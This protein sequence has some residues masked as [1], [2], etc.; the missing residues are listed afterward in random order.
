[1]K[2]HY[3]LNRPWISSGNDGVLED[4]AGFVADDEMRNKYN[5]LERISSAIGLNHKVSEEKNNIY[6]EIM[7]TFYDTISSFE[8][9]DISFYEHEADSID[10]EARNKER[11]CEKLKGFNDELD[12]NISDVLHKN[13]YHLTLNGNFLGKD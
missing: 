7:R 6:S 13:N 1:M 2:H 11:A 8:D 10:I 4:Y 12:H 9:V 5:L 3:V